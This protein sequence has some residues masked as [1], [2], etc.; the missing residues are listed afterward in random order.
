MG[1][2]PGRIGLSGFS[3]T[4]PHKISIHGRFCPQLTNAATRLWALVNIRVSDDGGQWIERQLSMSLWR[5]KQADPS[6]P[7]VL[8]QRDK[9][10]VYHGSWRRGCEAARLRLFAGCG[11]RSPTL[12]SRSEPQAAGPIS[13]RTCLI[14]LAN[15]GRDVFPNINDFSN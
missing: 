7:S 9:K 3:V 8:T 5:F 10:I 13:L 12:F 2:T 1:K 15:T 6:N 14:N 11:R 4:N